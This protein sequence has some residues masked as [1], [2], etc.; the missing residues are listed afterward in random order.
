MVAKLALSFRRF[1]CGFDEIGRESYIA[2]NLRS[3]AYFGPVLW[4]I[5]PSEEYQRPKATNHGA[6]L[7][8]NGLLEV[9][10]ACLGGSYASMI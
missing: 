4:A 6:S 7:I 5:R 9:P 3:S 2:A 8:S 10:E 1:R